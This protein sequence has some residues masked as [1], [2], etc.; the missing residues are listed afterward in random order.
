MMPPFNLPFHPTA[1]TIAEHDS[2]GLPSPH[3]VANSLIAV[4]AVIAQMLCLKAVYK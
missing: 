2:E 1:K 4:G 3:T